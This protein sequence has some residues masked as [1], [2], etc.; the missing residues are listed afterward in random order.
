MSNS[1][2]KINYAVRP[3]KNVE[4]KMMRDLFIRL[5]S[6]ARLEDYRYVGFGSKYFSDFILFHKIL[7]ISEMIS[8]EA[9]VN[10]RAR[11][12]FNK[13]YAGITMEWGKSTE[14][15]PKL[16][17]KEGKSIFWMDYDG[18]FEKYMLEDVAIISEKIESG[19]VLALSFN[20]ESLKIDKTDRE[21]DLREQ[22]IKMVGKEYVV[23]NLDTRGWKSSKKLAI[24]L[25]NCI[26]DKIKL[27][28]KSRNYGLSENDR[29][30]AKQKLF[31]MYADGAT[32]ATIAYVFSSKIDQNHAEACRFSDLYFVREDDEPF[33]I[34]TPNLTIKEVRHLMEIRPCVEKINT[35]IFAQKDVDALWENYRYFPGFSEIE[36]F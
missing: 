36:S 29:L 33:D 3:A 26:A 21:N 20:C 19:S 27:V 22:L 16:V 2:R 11:Y 31:F 35:K 32:M 1:G 17:A 14:V 8:I 6:F 12:E 15:L 5:R 34:S 28:L 23:N 9:D 18:L 4:R 30:E 24:F 10:N 13:P 7:N 25:K